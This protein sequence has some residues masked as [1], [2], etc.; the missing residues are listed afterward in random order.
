MSVSQNIYPML[1]T[2]IYLEYSRQ[3]YQVSF[4]KA[5]SHVVRHALSCQC[6]NCTLAKFSTSTSDKV[7][8][9]ANLA[10]EAIQERFVELT[11]VYKSYALTFL[12]SNT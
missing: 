5:F 8:V 11:K 2:F 10:I 12:I 9:T 7:K 1:T 6:Y 3:G 4:Q